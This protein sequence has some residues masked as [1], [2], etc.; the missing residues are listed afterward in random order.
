MAGARGE[1]PN[2]RGM[3]DTKPMD[4]EDTEKLPG[5]EWLS[6]WGAVAFGLVSFLVCWAT[7]LPDGVS[8]W[9]L[10]WPSWMIAFGLSVGLLGKEAVKLVAGPRMSKSRRR[11]LV[12]A[13][14]PLGFATTVM[15]SGR[16][17]VILLAAGSGFFFG[18]AYL[19]W[20]AVR[21]VGNTDTT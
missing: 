15:V 17:E 13:I 9:Q 18:Y 1:T 5:D 19:I 12:A 7:E 21:R 3:A 2:L 6:F 4:D 16:L 20:L 14:W 11:R 10:V 8:V